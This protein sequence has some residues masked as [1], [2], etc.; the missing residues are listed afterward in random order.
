MAYIVKY[1]D[2]ALAENTEIDTLYRKDIKNG[3]KVLLV[4]S[5]EYRNVA[6]KYN[7]KEIACSDDIKKS[8]GNLFVLF[9]AKNTIEISLDCAF[10]LRCECQIYIK[11]DGIFSA[12]PAFTDFSHRI[13]KMDYD[14]LLEMTVCGYKAIDTDIVEKARKNGIVL[15]FLS[16]KDEYGKGTVVKEVLGISGMT[17]KGIIKDPNMSIVS[18]IGVPD[19]TGICYSIFNLISEND[20]VVD[21]ISLPTAVRGKGEISFT[22]S[23]SDRIKCEKMLA[24]NKDKIGFSGLFVDD[25][26]AKVSVIGAALKTTKG[27]AAK[28]FKVLYENGIDVK[29]I[30]TSEIKLTVFVNRKMSDI[31][32]NKIHEMFIN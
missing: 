19:I 11:Y 22:V 23:R 31:A 28:V 12:D 26:I 15:H 21:T 25:D 24:E 2:N 14:E 20:I 13:D 5:A 1:I 17:V 27:V 30:N 29:L 9:C 32:V 10:V 8:D 3:Y 16:Y 6:L 7:A 4:C 18:L